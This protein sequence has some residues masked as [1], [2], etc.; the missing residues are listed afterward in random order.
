MGI[1]QLLK[2]GAGGGG[3]PPVTDIFF[4]SVTTPESFDRP[5]SPVTLTPP[6]GVIPGDHLIVQY[7]ANA[8][9]AGLAAANSGWTDFG[10]SVQNFELFERIAD[11]TSDDN[12]VVPANGEEGLFIMSAWGRSD[13]ALFGL[14]NFSNSGLSSGFHP[15]NVPLFVANFGTG[16]TRCMNIMFGWTFAFEDIVGTSFVQNFP[17]GDYAIAYEAAAAPGPD[18]ST[19]AF[20][21]YYLYEATSTALPAYTP[22]VL[23]AP[24]VG[25]KAY[26]GQQTR[27]RWN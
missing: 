25:N 9:V 26:L 21:C 5:G 19:M 14:E 2:A 24:A 10:Y 6:A 11:G 22:Q 12:F 20:F 23:P 8:I 7:N 17:V 3:G 16:Q 18:N 4:R 15:T 13:A 27:W 1:G